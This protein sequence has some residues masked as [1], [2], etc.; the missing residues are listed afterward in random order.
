M[1]ATTPRK[2][3]LQMISGLKMTS[4]EGNLPTGISPYGG[5]V[6]VATFYSSF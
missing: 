2:R 5:I 4:K 3:M 1:E 6:K